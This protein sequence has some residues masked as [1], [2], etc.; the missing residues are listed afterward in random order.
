MIYTRENVMVEQGDVIN[1]FYTYTIPEGV[2]VND[3]F[4]V[5][6]RQLSE[7][8]LNAGYDVNTPNA[9]RQFYWL[10]G[11]WS[12]SQVPGSIMIRPVV[13]SPLIITSVHDTYYKN[14]NLM[15]IW[16]NPATDY[17]NIEPGE[18]Q[19]SG[20]SYITITDLN[21]HE[22][23]KVPFSD[24]VDISSLHDG[25]YFLVIN[26]NGTACRI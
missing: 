11:E 16:P 8:F 10:N 5:G 23:I 19:L 3:I 17:I 9:G 22:L 21:G 2:V 13:G 20:S 25:M 18:L 15:N 14:K 26:V 12:Q 24:K 1:G 4:Y 6:W 7:T